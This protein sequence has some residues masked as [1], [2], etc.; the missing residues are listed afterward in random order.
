MEKVYFLSV[1]SIADDGSWLYD[2]FYPSI[3]RAEMSGEMAISQ[4]GISYSIHPEHLL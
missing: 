3:E 2:G 1:Y 4:G